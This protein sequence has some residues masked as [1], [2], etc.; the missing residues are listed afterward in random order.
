MT[1]DYMFSL[2]SG[3]Q[4]IKNKILRTYLEGYCPEMADMIDIKK[5]RADEFETILK[6]F[7]EKCK[8]TD[9]DW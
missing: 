4:V 7:E 2:G 6:D 5:Y 8:W 1:N 9:L 3:E